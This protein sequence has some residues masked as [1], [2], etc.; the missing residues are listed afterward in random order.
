MDLILKSFIFHLAT[1]SLPFHPNFFPHSL[2]PEYHPL[3]I[4]THLNNPFFLL[5]WFLIPQ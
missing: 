2:Y 4:H 5:N 3:S 1:P